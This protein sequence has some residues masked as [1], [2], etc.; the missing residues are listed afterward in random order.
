MTNLLSVPRII[1]CLGFDGIYP[2]VIFF[3][4][5]YGDK[6]EPYRGYVLT[7]L[8][9]E[10]FLLIA[11]LNAIANLVSNFYLAAYAFINFCTFHAAIV[12]PLGWRP[13]FTFYNK[14]LS[15]FMTV[16]CVVIMFLIDWL[17]ALITIIII[18]ALY[19]YVAYRK[20]D[21]NWGATTQAQTYNTTLSAVSTLTQHGE[22]VKNYRPQI[23]VLA[24]HPTSRPAL[25]D[26]ANL[27]TKHLALL[28][29]GHVSQVLSAKGRFRS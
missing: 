7:L 12:K 23:L 11:D 15:L 22:H 29:C 8:V 9:A 5:G 28:V 6:G 17:T 25:L 21:V 14:W 18:I 24:G 27:I 26:F 19:V 13:S 1:Q 4:K 2:G 10:I 3:S 20:P 16:L